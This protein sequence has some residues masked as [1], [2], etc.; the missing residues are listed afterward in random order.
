MSAG[1]F[2]KSPTA[3]EKKWINLKIRYRS[4]KDNMGKSGAGRTSWIYFDKMNDILHRDRSTEPAATSSSYNGQSTASTPKR[5]DDTTVTC[6]ETGTK[7]TKE[8]Q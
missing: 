7:K 8:D 5:K 2:K 3:C 1:G 6:P 4:I